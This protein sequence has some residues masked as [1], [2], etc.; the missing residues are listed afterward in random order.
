M[1]KTRVTEEEA[2]AFLGVMVGRVTGF[3]RLTEGEE[4]QVFAFDAGGPFVLRINR[5]G[6][7]FAKDRLMQLRFGAFL[8]I[9]KVSLIAP[10]G[11]AV[12][13]ISSRVPG[14]TLQD[15]TADETRVVAPAVAEVM[16]AMA[17]CDMQGFGG[18][19]L[20]DAEGKGA[21]GTWGSFLSEIATRD[22][23]GIPDVTA[24]LG[25]VQ[26]FAETCPDH[27]KLVHGDF[28]SNNVLC[29]NGQITGV[30]DW[31]EAM[32]GDPLFDLA[33]I[34]FWR[35]WLSCMEVQASYF[36]QEKPPGPATAET[37]RIYSLR[38]ALDTLWHAEQDKEADLADWTRSRLKELL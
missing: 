12:A 24:A 35:S 17:A 9:P 28:G 31:S 25:A 27:R 38:I 33:N 1:G 4:S 16:D 30:I 34:L 8:P 37:L 3:R 13:C 7:G 2:L 26:R 20:F 29:D 5:D 21:F 11:D 15:L 19:G 6:K 23:Q 36:Q 32:S 18:A 10:L 14:V 22:W